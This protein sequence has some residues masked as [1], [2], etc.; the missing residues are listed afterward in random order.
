MPKPIIGIK[1]PDSNFSVELTVKGMIFRMKLFIFYFN[2]F[3]K[4][5]NLYFLNKTQTEMEAK[6]YCSFQVFFIFRDNIASP[7][8]C[9]IDEIQCLHRHYH[10]H[11]TKFL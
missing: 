10:L 11:F 1:L 3:W 4:V 8:I 2:N 5:W 9:F 7:Y 6:C